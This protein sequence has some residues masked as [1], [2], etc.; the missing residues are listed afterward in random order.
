MATDSFDLSQTHLQ[1]HDDGAARRV[2]VTPTFWQG[3]MAGRRSDH[4]GGP[5]AHVRMF[6][7]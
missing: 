4:A 2:E 7:R 3:V 5:A 1:L 6:G